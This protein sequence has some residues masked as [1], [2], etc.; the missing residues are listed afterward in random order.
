MGVRTDLLAQASL[1]DQAYDLATGL[2]R[3]VAE[4]HPVAAPL[5]TLADLLGDLVQSQRET[6]RRLAALLSELDG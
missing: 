4:D 5:G 2:R 3:L 1:T 6:V